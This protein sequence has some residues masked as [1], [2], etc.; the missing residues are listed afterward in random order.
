MGLFS[1]KSSSTSTTE[2]LDQRVVAD[3]GSQA[4]SASGDASVAVLDGGAITSAF[5][6]AKA[7]ADYRNQDFRQLLNASESIT[8][9]GLDALESSRAGIESAYQKSA[10]LTGR[11]LDTATSAVQA[12]FSEAKGE[13]STKLIA[14]SVLAGVVLLVI[15]FVFTRRAAA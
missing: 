7:E 13:G 2:N 3:G 4:I 10:M 15:G 12:A 11:A 6:F 8:V 5:E 1:S 9:A 14:Y